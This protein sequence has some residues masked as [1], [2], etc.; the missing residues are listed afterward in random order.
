MHY[1]NGYLI[2]QTSTKFI[3][4]KILNEYDNQKDANDDLVNLLAHKK[5]EKELLKEFNSKKSW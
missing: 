1:K 4:C 3:L 2:H 5:T